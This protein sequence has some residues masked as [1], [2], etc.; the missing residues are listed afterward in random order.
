MNNSKNRIL[1]LALTVAFFLL[2]NGCASSDSDDNISSAYTSELEGTWNS[3]CRLHSGAGMDRRTSYVY[4]GSSFHMYDN[5]YDS[6]DDSCTG[7]GLIQ[8]GVMTFTSGGAIDTAGDIKKIDYTFVQITY[9]T[10]STKGITTANNDCSPDLTFA[11]IDETKVVTG[12]A[13][14]HWDLNVGEVMY[15]AY[16]IDTSVTPGIAHFSDGGA[17][18]EADRPTTVDTTNDYIKQD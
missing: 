9:T 18:T 16:T 2:N 10:K 3:T 13:C 6:T 7:I 15:A 14:D 4:A 17:S 8:D 11:T 5:F 1:L 12:T